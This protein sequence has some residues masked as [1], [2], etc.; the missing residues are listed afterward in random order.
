MYCFH[1]MLQDELRKLQQSLADVDQSL[2]SQRQRIQ[3][4]ARTLNEKNE[5]RDKLQNTLASIRNDIM[6]L[7]A[8]EYPSENEV[9]IL[10]RFL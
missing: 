6:E 8:V 9:E 10:V 5:Q 7:E 1:R 2:E 3:Q 4:I